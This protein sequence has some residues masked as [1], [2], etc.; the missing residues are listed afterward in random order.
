M[1]TQAVPLA[2][3]ELQDEPS[4]NSARAIWHQQIESGYRALSVSATELTEMTTRYCSEPDD[5]TRQLLESHWREAFLDWQAVRFV[6]FGPIEL[7]SRA[8][9]LQFWPD[10]KN[11]VD[12]KARQL[13]SSDTPIDRQ[14][15]ADFGVA[16]EGFP[17][18][19]YLLFDDSFN[20]SDRALPNSRSCALL[21]ATADIVDDNAT[22]LI[23]D[24]EAMSDHYLAS[25]NYT[26]TTIR[27]AMTALNILVQKRLGEPMGL[28]STHRRLVFA[29]DAWRS[30]QS[31]AAV[32]ASLAGLQWYFLPGVVVELEQAEQRDIA[33]DLRE[34]LQSTLAKF[35]ALP[36]DFATVLD[37][38]ERYVHLQ[39]LYIAMQQLEQTLELKAAAALDIRQGFNSSDGD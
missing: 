38:E 12:T 1:S 28:G 20:Q 31:L 29:G 17:M 8:W 36:A 19:E 13:L 35:D 22:H 23:S 7:D 2:L 21:T 27:S 16:A 34:Q 14:R 25:D 39:N 5:A 24:W 30:G 10:P 4:Q 26:A 32:E 15:V 33:N 6:D 9:Q 11:L 18:L 3:A 37:S